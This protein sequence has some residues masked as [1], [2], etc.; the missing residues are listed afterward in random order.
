[1]TK[2]DDVATR[3][4]DWGTIKWLVSPET[5]PGTGMTMCEVIVYP[6]KGH[7]EHNHPDAEET[8]Y[9][10]SGTGSQTVGGAGP[11][12]IAPGDAVYVPLGEMHSTMNTGWAPLHILVTYNPAGAERAIDADP[13]VRILPPG[14][15]PV[16]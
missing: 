7:A 9:V 5:D 2:P 1:M 13:T 11:F 4:L 16:A 14:E 10:I 15:P 12:D 3:V 8:I 6:G